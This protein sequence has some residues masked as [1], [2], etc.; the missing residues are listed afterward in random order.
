[1]WQEFLIVT[2]VYFP[3]AFNWL[4]PTGCS[5]RMIVGCYFTHSSSSRL[6]SLDWK[7]RQSPIPITFTVITRS[8][9]KQCNH[10]QVNTQERILQT[11]HHH[12]SPSTSDPS[13]VAAVALRRTK[14]TSSVSHASHHSSTLIDDLPAASSA[15]Q[16]ALVAAHLAFARAGSGREN[17]R[18]SNAG[19]MAVIHE[20][21]NTE[22]EYGGT[23][24]KRE[25]SQRSLA[26]GEYLSFVS[27]VGGKWY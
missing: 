8:S 2:I 27:F 12:S 22:K 1:M 10:Q 23:R 16:H 15:S 26:S 3:L 19:V 6:C 18:V 9:Q 20:G 5:F 13:P 17:G 11:M 21:T 14:S 4:L 25:G 24:L 7:S